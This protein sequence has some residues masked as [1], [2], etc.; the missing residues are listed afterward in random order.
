M[1]RTANPS[2]PGHARGLQRTAGHFHRRFARGDWSAAR[3]ASAF[4]EGPVLIN[5]IIYAELSVGFDRIES[6]DEA[7]SKQIESEALDRQPFST[8]VH[9]ARAVRTSV[10]EVLPR[11]WP[12][13]ISSSARATVSSGGGYG[14]RRGR[15]RRRRAARRLGAVALRRR[16]RSPQARAP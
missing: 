4:D 11:P 7:L 10:S 8:G 5:P 6:L 3:L 2:E 1:P 12:P 15:V 14:T 13:I 16:I 9:C